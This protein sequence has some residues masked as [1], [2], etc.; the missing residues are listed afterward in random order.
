MTTATAPA[1]ESVARELVELCRTG[2]NMEALEK[3]YAPD[4]VSIEASDFEGMPARM[5][6]L[7]AIRQKNAWWFN[8]FT[9]NSSAA[10]GPYLNGEQF[11]VKFTF[12]TTNKKT[13]ER[14]EGSEVAL[15]TVKEGKI[16]EERFYYAPK[17]L[18]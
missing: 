13:G 18:T 9:V 14:A 16:V 12:D 8:S 15:Y 4:I 11:A 10:D 3:L 6:G 7:E 5:T 2:R 1:T 17:H